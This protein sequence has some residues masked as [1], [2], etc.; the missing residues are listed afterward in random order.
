MGTTILFNAHIRKKNSSIKNQNIGRMSTQACVKYEFRC[1]SDVNKFTHA[2]HTQP[3]TF[4]NITRVGMMQ[5]THIPWRLQ[6]Q[7]TAA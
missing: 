4:I 2:K 3:M 5:Q 7:S 1:T 6:I